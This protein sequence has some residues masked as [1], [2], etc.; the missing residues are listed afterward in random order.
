MALTL[1]A[2]VLDYEQVEEAVNGMRRDGGEIDVLICAAGI[3]GAIGPVWETPPSSWARTIETNLIGVLHACRAVLPHMVKRRCGKIIALAGPGAM[4]SR[5][6]FS[7]Y[8]AA[9]AAVVRMVET[10]ADEAREHNVQANCLGPGPTYTHM[11]D[12][13]LRAG[14]LAGWKEH[15]DAVKIRLTG[16]APPDKQM[17]LA[18]FLAS[19]ES[20]HIS[21]KLL[22][23]E[24]NWKRLRRG[25]VHSELYTLRRVRK[26]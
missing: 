1:R 16:G 5:P 4:R 13:I 19:E 10:I 2:D 26:V 6:N 15:E 24:D 3:Q 14:E 8:A 11:T 20:N 9:K 21:G 23:I 12:E 22:H 17:E 18:A 25:N 7:A